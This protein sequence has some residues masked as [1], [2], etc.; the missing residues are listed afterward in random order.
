MFDFSLH[1]PNGNSRWKP[2]FNTLPIIQK[3]HLIV[4]HITYHFRRCFLSGN[5]AGKCYRI[6]TILFG[7]LFVLLDGWVKKKS[8]RKHMMHAAAGLALLGILVLSA[9]PGLFEALGGGEIEQY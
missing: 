8:L 7:I 9:I 1:E 3:S 4:R 2:K 5:R 6:D